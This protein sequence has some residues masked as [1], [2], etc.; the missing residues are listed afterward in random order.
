MT[1]RERELLA[2]EGS[3]EG[4]DEG[5]DVVE[6]LLV[7]LLEL[8][9]MA[10]EAVVAWAGVLKLLSSWKVSSELRPLSSI[11]IPEWTPPWCLPLFFC[12]LAAEFLVGD[13]EA[14]LLVV[15]GADRAIPLP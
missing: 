15:W 6:V 1:W 14:L 12:F 8:V 5:K 9:V 10:G 7:L 4:L 13:L 2:G 11:L 3:L